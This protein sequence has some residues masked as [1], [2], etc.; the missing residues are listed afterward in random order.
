[1]KRRLNN[2]LKKEIDRKYNIYYAYIVAR[3]LNQQCNGCSAEYHHF[4]KTNLKRCLSYHKWCLK[5]NKKLT[6]L[7]YCIQG[8]NKRRYSPELVFNALK[9]FK[10]NHPVCDISHPVSGGEN[11]EYAQSC[12]LD[13]RIS[14][15]FEVNDDGSMKITSFGIVKEDKHG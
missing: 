14:P 9:D 4:K 15:R 5:H 13:F 6:D 3:K 7:Y 8:K 11:I 12:V 1:M 2:I 10:K